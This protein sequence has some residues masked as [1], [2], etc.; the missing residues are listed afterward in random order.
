MCQHQQHMKKCFWNDHFQKRKDFLLIVLKQLLMI[1]Y[2]VIYRIYLSSLLNVKAIMLPNLIGNK[3]DWELLKTSLV[4]MG[5]DDI[6]LI[7]DSADTIG[8]TINKKNTGK[9]NNARKNTFHYLVFF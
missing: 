8:Y 4:S 5:R 7:E 9:D 6:Y 3:P 2:V 1:E